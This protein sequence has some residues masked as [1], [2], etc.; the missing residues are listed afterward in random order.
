MQIEEGGTYRTSAAIWTVE[1]ITQDGMVFVR[2]DDGRTA[3]YGLR[4]FA[5]WVVSQVS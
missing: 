4:S 2:R 3:R 1:S 5:S